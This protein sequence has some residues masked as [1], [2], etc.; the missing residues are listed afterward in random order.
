MRVYVSLY[1][2]TSILHSAAALALLEGYD[3]GLCIYEIS[4][5]VL[6][7]GAPFTIFITFQHDSQQL[8][9][10]LWKEIGSPLLTGLEDQCIIDWTEIQI[11][12]RIGTGSYGE[13][14]FGKWKETN[15]AV[16]KLFIKNL[17]E[18]QLEE[19]KSEA[20][21]LS[22]LKH[23]NVV[24]MLGVTVER[25]LAIVTE[26]M[27]RGNLQ[28]MLANPAQEIN[29]NLRLKFAMDIINGVSYMHAFQPCI[30]H[31]DLKSANLLVDEH[32][33]IKISDLGLARIKEEKTMTIVGTVAW[34]SP[35]ILRGKRYNERVDVYSFGIILWELITR[36]IPH[37]ELQYFEV[38]NRVTTDI[39]RPSIPKDCPPLYKSLMESCWH[40]DPTQRPAS[41]EVLERLSEMK[42]LKDFED[43]YQ[44]LD[45][46]H[47]G[48]Y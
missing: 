1:L 16:K 25:N 6:A 47:Q 34:T 4:Y 29:W 41:G 31:R 3:F 40:D 10:Q 44:D 5:A 37:K 9:S 21:L 7:I 27:A 12:A 45:A 36:E 35:E 43:T 8:Q 28:H 11:G 38:I 2:L 26:F 20:S 14:Y 18:K 32:F 22:K 33:N 39:L 13:V 42:S 19:F 30:I 23:K 24:Q 15:V 17:N 48:F 46:P